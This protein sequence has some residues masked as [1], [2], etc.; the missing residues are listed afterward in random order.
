M[1][2]TTRPSRAAGADP[3]QLYEALLADLPE[4]P[5]VTGALANRWAAVRTDL[6]D[7]G[8]AMAY[9]SGPRSPSEAW[10]VTGRPLREVAAL[11]T[12]WDLRLASVGVAALN[13]WYAAPDRLA[14]R[15]GITWGPETGFF[16]RLAAEVGVRRTVVVGHFPDVESLTGDVTVLERTPRG[17]DLPDS[18]A[19]YVLP[20]AEL[21]AITGSTVVNKTLPRLLELAKDA[22][23][24]LLGPSAPPHPDAYPPCVVGLAGSCVVDPDRAW[25]HVALGVS[26]LVRSDAL[27]MFAIE[28][29]R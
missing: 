9:P 5:V 21:V 29:P 7:V 24:H 19:E 27:R 6:G 17:D 25:H 13:A 11:A 14:A 1:S 23:V 16:R 3:W 20:D 2:G 12:S 26:G 10:Q 28:I 4:G 15:P 8:V 22:D 18:A